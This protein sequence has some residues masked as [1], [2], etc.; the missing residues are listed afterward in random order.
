MITVYTEVMRIIEG[1]FMIPVGSP[2]RSHLFGDG[3]RVL[4]QE[5]CYVLKG[6]PLIKL[7][8]YVLT[9]IKFKVFLV[10]GDESTHG[11]LFPLLSE[12]DLTIAQIYERV[13]L[14]CAALNSTTTILGGI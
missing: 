1:A 7:R 4:T 3:G 11:Y 6:C 9:V 10:T 2:V 14:Y 12:R 13:N 8:L 5:L